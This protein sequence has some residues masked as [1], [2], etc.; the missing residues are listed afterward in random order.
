MIL[1]DDVSK[2]FLECTCLVTRIKSDCKATCIPGQSRL[3]KPNGSVN[4]IKRGSVASRNR[5]GR[6]ASGSGNNSES[7]IIVLM[8][9]DELE[10]PN[11][12]NKQ[13]TIDCQR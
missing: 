12:D 7:C 11:G 9:C 8:E 3:P 6:N 4:S 13:L 5:S 2:A 10:K 1:S